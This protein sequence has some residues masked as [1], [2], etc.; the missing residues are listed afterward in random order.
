MAV[1]GNGEK[2]AR[3]RRYFIVKV[4]AWIFITNT[5]YVFIGIP[6]IKTFNDFITYFLTTNGAIATGIFT[7]VGMT[8]LKKKKEI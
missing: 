8:T 7:W 5:L 2:K 3:S 6:F 1:N 4:M